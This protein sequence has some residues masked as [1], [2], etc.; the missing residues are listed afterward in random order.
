MLRL[1]L[2][3]Y[4]RDGS[5]IQPWL[6]LLEGRVPV[7][8]TKSEDAKLRDPW[9]RFYMKT[10]D[11]ENEKMNSLPRLFAAAFP[12]YTVKLGGRRMKGKRITRRRRVF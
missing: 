4:Y 6:V 11:L 1:A 3:K 7:L 2:K 5:S 8:R 12:N 10:L 9:Y